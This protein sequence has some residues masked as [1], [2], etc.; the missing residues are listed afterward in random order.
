MSRGLKTPSANTTGNEYY[1][2]GRPPSWLRPSISTQP[3][4]HSRNCSLDILFLIIQHIRRHPLYTEPMPNQTYFQDYRAYN[5]LYQL[6]RDM[7]L[8]DRLIDSIY[9]ARRL[10]QFVP[11]EPGLPGQYRIDPS[12]RLSS[13]NLAALHL[14]HT[15]AIW[16]H[17]RVENPCQISL[18]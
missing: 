6:R 10:L 17:Y 7:M 8:M 1:L 16:R 3:E 18:V 5:I 15:A 2:P 9:Q 4:L 12:A 11:G 13:S 14:Q